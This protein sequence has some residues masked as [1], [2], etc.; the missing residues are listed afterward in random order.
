MTQREV[1]AGWG[2]EVQKL[3][4]AKAIVGG[5]VGVAPDSVLGLYQSSKEVADL[6]EEERGLSLTLSE[7]KA[8]FFPACRGPLTSLQTVMVETPSRCKL[9]GVTSP[10]N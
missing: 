10:N 5:L 2:E 6:V 3:R 9:A 8:G 1:S 7:A 4:V